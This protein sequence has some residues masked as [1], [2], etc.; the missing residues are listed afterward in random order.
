MKQGKIF[1]KK[2]LDFETKE[3]YNL[4]VF[5]IVGEKSISNNLEINVINVDD[6]KTDISF[7]SSKVH[8]GSS[9]DSVIG[10]AIASGDSN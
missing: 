5:T 9:L 1:I 4:F 10:N 7:V 3:T 2:E 8:E 6:L